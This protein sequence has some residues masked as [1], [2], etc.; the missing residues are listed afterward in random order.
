MAKRES[1]SEK[2]EGWREITAQ[3]EAEYAAPK[4]RDTGTKVSVIIP[5]YQAEETLQECVLSVKQQSY[6]DLEILLIDDGSTDEGGSLCDRLSQQDDRIKVFHEENRG[7]SKEPAGEPP[8]NVLSPESHIFTKGLPV[9]C[10]PRH[11]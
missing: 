7:V 10:S 6:V 8:S 1:L 9:T 3:M 5:V 2:M 11:S 4:R